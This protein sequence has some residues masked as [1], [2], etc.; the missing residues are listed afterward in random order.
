MQT[1]LKFSPAIKLSE[2]F[3]T[4]CKKYKSDAILTCKC[5]ILGY[6]NDNIGKINKVSP[7]YDWA[8]SLVSVNQIY[9]Y[10]T[11]TVLWL[12]KCLISEGLFHACAET[13]AKLL[14]SLCLWLW[15]KFCLRISFQIWMDQTFDVCLNWG[16]DGWWRKKIKGVWLVW[17]GGLE[18]SPGWR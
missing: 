9:G 2:L 11:S 13:H 6:L 17:R 16:Y 3:Q 15:Q 5:G 18:E 10:S 4:R 7:I 12:R 8:V 14:A 1:I